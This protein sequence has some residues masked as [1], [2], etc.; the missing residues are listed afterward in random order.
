MDSPGVNTALLGVHWIWLYAR[1][2]AK[3]ALRKQILDSYPIARKLSPKEGGFE[4]DGGG[5]PP[6]SED[7]RGLSAVW[8][9]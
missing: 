3:N 8:P 4:D 2:K 5:S 1:S 7:V 9:W 6:A